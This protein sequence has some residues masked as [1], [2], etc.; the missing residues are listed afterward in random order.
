MDNELRHHGIKGQKWGIRRFQN[1]DGT[2]TAAGKQRAAANHHED[3]KRAH[4]P[5]SVSSMSDKELKERINRLQ[6]EKQYSQLSPSNVSRGKDYVQKVIKAGTTVAT[7]TT[8]GLTIYNNFDKI[9]KII[10][11]AK[12]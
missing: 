7:I 9:S 3:Y 12:K 6:M 11:K 1:K 5:K 4:E 2:L 10:G 8:T